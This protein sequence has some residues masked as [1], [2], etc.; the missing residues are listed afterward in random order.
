MVK[1][2]GIL[3]VTPDSF[4]DGGKFFAIDAALKQAEQL[5]SEGADIIDVGGES[6]RPQSSVVPEEEEIKR[7]V[8][9]I[10]EIKKRFPKQPVS[11][12][13]YKSGVAAAAIDSGAEIVNDIYGLG[14]GNG[15]MADVVAKNNVS[16]II[17]HMKGTPQDMQK[18]PQ[19]K[20]VVSEINR[21]FKERIKYAKSKGIKKDKIILDPGIG[22]G[23]TLKHN[24]EILK[25]LSK[26]RRM[27]FPVMV[28]PSRKSF[29]GGLLNV[30]PVRDT[31]SRSDISNRVDVSNRLEGT[32]AASIYSLLNG[33]DYLRVHDVLSVKRAITVFEAIKN[34]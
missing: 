33:A 13:T 4:S 24:L 26:F 3:N 10:S 15:E 18:D 7:V 6:T 11:I 9:V 14:F 31:A 16:V 5:I 34:V 19:Y 12:D 1:I 23:K 27:G 32:I 20:D 21:F 8:P 25:N 2:A 29:I 30:D 28:G 17:M 22:F